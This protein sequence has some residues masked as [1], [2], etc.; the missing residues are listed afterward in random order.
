MVLFFEICIARCLGWLSFE[1]LLYSCYGYHV[2]ALGYG[3]L[4]LSEYAK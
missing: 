4:Q 1:V 3:S 2:R